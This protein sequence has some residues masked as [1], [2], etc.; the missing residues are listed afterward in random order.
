MQ[1]GH[2][3]QSSP[4]KVMSMTNISTWKQTI[5]TYRH[6]S[7]QGHFKVKHRVK[8]VKQGDVWRSFQS[9]SC[10]S[11]RNNI[12]TRLSCEMH[13]A[14]AASIYCQS[15]TTESHFT[16]SINNN[17]HSHNAINTHWLLCLFVSSFSRLLLFINLWHCAPPFSERFFYHTICKLRWY[18]WKYTYNTENKK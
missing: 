3:G 11:S 4:A 6:R 2:R 5:I 8:E 15:N 13:S 12:I 16:H 9:H 10:N 1:Q 18:F 17:K 7:S 14:A